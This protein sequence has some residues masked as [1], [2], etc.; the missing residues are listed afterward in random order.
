MAVAL[1]NSAQNRASRPAPGA[2]DLKFEIHP[3]AHA[4]SVNDRVAKLADP[5]FGR[6]FTD[7]MSIV[8]YNQ[9][10]AGM[11]RGSNPAPI[12]PL[13]P[14]ASR[15]CTTPRK[16]S[17]AEGLHARRWRGEPVP[18][19]R[20]CQTLLGLPPTAWRWRSFRN[21]S[22]SRRS[23]KLLRIDRD[24]IPGGEGSLYCVPS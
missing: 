9:A 21:R 24:W 7:H 17:R 4:T 1:E 6:V 12:S 20:Q 10:R 14:V 13:D 16:S 2:V 23:S 18:A 11:T 3:T 8:R 22:S 19:R 15:S 5:G